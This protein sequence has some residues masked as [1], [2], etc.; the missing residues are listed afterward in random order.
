MCYR[1]RT[2]VMHKGPVWQRFVWEVTLKRRKFRL[3][4]SNISQ[5]DTV[6]CA[7]IVAYHAV[8]RVNTVS[9]RYISHINTLNL[10]I[11]YTGMVLKNSCFY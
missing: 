1:I 6:F 3:N 10:L 9:K 5:F 11:L 2:T 4:M 8:T 7:V